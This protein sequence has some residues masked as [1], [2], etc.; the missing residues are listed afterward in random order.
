MAGTGISVVGFVNNDFSANSLQVFMQCIV[1]DGEPTSYDITAPTDAAEQVT[2]CSITSLP[3]Q[4]HT[5]KVIIGNNGAHNVLID[6]F[7]VSTSE[8]S[9]TS[10]TQHA[11]APERP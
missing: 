8:A 9:P 3:N 7:N 1:D 4:Q 2:F 10:V 6:S 11:P 5:L